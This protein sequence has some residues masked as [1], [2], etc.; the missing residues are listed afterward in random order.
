MYLC[1]Y[2]SDRICVMIVLSIIIGGTITNK[3][4]IEILKEQ[5]LYTEKPARK[6]K[7]SK[8]KVVEQMSSAV[9]DIIANPVV[10]KKRSVVSF[11]KL[12]INRIHVLSQL[13]K[14]KNYSP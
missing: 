2:I 7:Q 1:Q 10:S 8:V 9:A 4:K 12:I 6:A 3:E 11:T 14:L 13:F 5:G